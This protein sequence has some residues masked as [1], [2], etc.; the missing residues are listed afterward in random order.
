MKRMIIVLLMFTLI[1]VNY[2]QNKQGKIRGTVTDHNT[3]EKLI[4]VNILVLEKENTGTS[5]DLDGQY[6]LPSLPDGNYN[7]K[8]S[9]V[10]YESVTINVLLNKSID[11][12]LNVE[13]NE[14]AIK[15][16]E[17]VVT[18][19]KRNTLDDIRPSTID[20]KPLDVKNLAGGAEDVLRSLTSLPGV[21]GISDMSSQFAVRGSG[22]EQNLILID[23]FE[24]I[25]PYRLYGFTSMF[26]PETV[27][28]IDLQTGGFNAEYGDRLSSVLSVRSR[29]GNTD[30]LLSGKINT[31]LTNMNLILEGRL[32]FFENG[33]FLFSARRTY[34]DMIVGPIL[35]SSK[36][37]DGEVALPNFKDVQ[38]KL[39][40]PIN[41][42]NILQ[43][44][45]L[46]SGD[47]MSLVSSAGREQ[48]DSISAADNS[49]NSLVGLSYRFIP[50]D[51]L[52]VETQLSYY[53]NGGVGTMMMNMADPTQYD[54]ELSRQ[55]TAGISLMSWD[56]KYDY[57]YTKRSLLQKVFWKKGM[58]SLEFGYGVD[59]L[60]TDVTNHIKLNDNYREYLESMGQ[61]YP[62]DITESLSY[63][64]YNMFV[65]DALAMDKV[66]IKA[67][68][69]M[70]VYPMLK[71][72]VFLSP[73]V[74][75]SYRLDETSTLRAAYGRYYQ[76]PGMEKQD[77][78]N[79]IS[80]NKERLGNIMPESA[81]HFIMGYE[82]MLNERWQFKTEGYYKKL[83]DV[84]VPMKVD[85]M[86]KSARLT[87]QDVRNAESWTIVDG[88]YDSLTTVP[89]NGAEGEAYGIEMML[90]KI[91]KGKDDRFN[92]WI[93]YA[94]SFA[95]RERDGKRSPFKYDQRHAVNVAG[96]YRF[97]E[98]WELGFKFTLR[99]GKPYTA[100]LGVQPRVRT[101]N[102][103]GITYNTLQTNE[104][105]TAVLDVNYEQDNYSGKLNLYHS[106]DLRITNYTKWLGLD[107]SF[108]L[109][110]QNVYNR[111]NQEQVNYF[112]DDNGS[113]KEKYTYGLPVFPSLGLSVSF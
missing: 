79:N 51:D 32:P 78:W 77:M 83:T 106:L 5:T 103:N 16:D 40:M 10:G 113:L 68:L 64:K 50:N 44:N 12:I 38:G 11:K 102:E 80:Y 100:A 75:I 17:V 31:S 76:S 82:K 87:G 37:F 59:A 39:V 26:N 112:I 93:S 65:S 88:R 20:I 109:D 8:F 15:V 107:W 35:K 54:E 89:V 91:N 21:T 58:H 90:E 56:Q 99:S 47:G 42:S 43:L 62:T 60:R 104:N 73:R 22:P 14:K 84:I 7:L 61:V 70:D 96:N 69:R 18:G 19:T 36:V 95:E 108:Y 52:M 23:G 45:V 98:N 57:K 110:V 4:G 105:G 72:E 49:N 66:T 33:S 13:M 97:A 2:G 71:K 24:V 30:R 46:A 41:S 3:G 67:G 81:E 74:N 1:S 28:E 25:N 48:I 27:S 63:N 9:L 53:Q 6:E 55:D 101:V 111:K 94:L 92:G 34:Y 86:G 85:V 29:S